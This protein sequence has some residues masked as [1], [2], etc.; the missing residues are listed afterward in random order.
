MRQ[1]YKLKDGSIVPGTT[2]IANMLDKPQLVNWAWKLGQQG[3]DWREERDNAGDVGTIV[4]GMIMNFLKND[5]FDLSDYKPLYCF[6]AA[7]RCFTK[8]KKWAKPKSIDIVLIEHPLVSERFRYG[9]TLDLYAKVNG[10]NRL[11]DVKTSGGIY[12]SHWLQLAGYDI[13][14]EENGYFMDEY[15]ILWLPKDDRFDAPIKIDLTREKII[16]KSLLNIYKLRN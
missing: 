12:E 8:F 14:L 15:Q 1:P 16:F 2:T 9:G 4:H 3:L 7:R 6:K 5:D 10:K 13:L 11:I